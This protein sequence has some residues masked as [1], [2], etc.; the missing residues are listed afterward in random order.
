MKRSPL[1]VV[2]ITVFLDLL[3]FGIILPLMPYYALQLGASGVWV[4]ALLTAFSVGQ[5][6]G[7]PF[8]GRLSDRLG[9]RPVLL[10]SLTGAVI[11]FTLTG[12]ANTLYFLI[13]SRAFAGL[14]SG[15]I[16]TAQAYI[17]DTTKPEERTK[18]MG[19]LGASIG[20]G[21][22][23]GPAVGAGFSRFGFG[24]ASFIAA[25]LAAANLLF[26]YFVLVEPERHVERASEKVSILKVPAYLRAAFARPAL[27]R[28]LVTG[29][30][31]MASFVS[32]EATFALLA[33]Q[34]FGLNEGHLGLVF[35]YLGVIIVAIQ[36]G[37]IGP[38]GKRFGERNL[39][40]AGSLAIAGSMIL[41]PLMPNLTFM[42]GALGITA[43]GQGL[44]MPSFSSL[45]SLASGA[46][47]QGSMLGL[48][49]SLAS[50][51]RASGPLVA[52]FLY[53]LGPN[54]PYFW[55]AALALV[56]AGMLM[57]VHVA[58]PSPAESTAR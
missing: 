30:L 27:G 26:A 50:A 3:G 37:F 6:I 4:G 38:L 35:T 58:R 54:L 40:I 5:F 52:G 12:F 24:T 34:K 20:M 33:K 49:Q 39:T 48:N 21:F 42:M 9:R 16:S 43:V 18:Y 15:S 8:L 56:A 13:A 23:L 53:D 14:F 11:S 1:I 22:V 17:A 29:F 32:L 44:C 41:L 57:G 19:I 55:G 31:V 2:Y 45:I 36:G 46:D 47:E 51:A 25:G 28:I 10:V 7:A